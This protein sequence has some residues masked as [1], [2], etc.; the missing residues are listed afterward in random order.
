MINEQRV[1]VGVFNR[2]A[3]A[4]LAVAELL[5]AG[6]PADAISVI[7]PTCA[8]DDF[9]PFKKVEPAGAH[10]PRAAA[11][12][13]AIG[14]VLGGLVAAVGLVATGGTGLLIVGPL[15]GGMATGGVVGGFIGA[16]TTRGIETE[17]ANFYDQ[18]LRKGSIL[19]AVE[20]PH[21]HDP[22]LVEAERVFADVGSEPLPLP[23]G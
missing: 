17:I 11:T 10:T 6:I 20:A 8:K 3:S 21:D 1:R 22:L 12:G 2:L 9:E 14:G 23:K 15:L 16:M 7:C 5:E 18:A 4:D 19:V 13:S